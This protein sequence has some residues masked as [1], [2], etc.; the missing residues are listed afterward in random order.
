[1]T[2][3]QLESLIRLAEARA[4]LEMREVVTQRDA[5]DAVELMKDTLY[6]QFS[7]A[8]GV[9]DLGRAAGREA[10]MS[11]DKKVCALLRGLQR[12]CGQSGTADM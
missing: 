9:V 6:E 3:R 7:D 12:Y 10:G 8:H 5:V 1:V 2:T 4:K 11:M